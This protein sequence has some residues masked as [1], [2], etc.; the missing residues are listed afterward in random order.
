MNNSARRVTCV[1]TNLLSFLI[2]FLVIV[3]HALAL[4]GSEPGGQ[5]ETYLCFISC[6]YEMSSRPLAKEQRDAV[7]NCALSAAPSLSVL[8]C[9]LD[10]AVGQAEAQGD[11]LCNDA[12][13]QC[14]FDWMRNGEE[15]SDPKTRHKIMK[16]SIILSGFA[17]R[18]V[19]EAVCIPL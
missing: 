4:T 8:G 1:C 16:A 7:K 12:L 17:D 15:V 19:P 13:T 9:G 2:I 3:P 6:N 14:I 10:D 11:K 18:P 5:C